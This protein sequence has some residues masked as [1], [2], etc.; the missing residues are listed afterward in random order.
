MGRMVTKLRY[1]EEIII[2]KVVKIY[3]QEGPEKLGIV[4]ECPMH[5]EIEK[6][7]KRNGVQET[8]KRKA[9]D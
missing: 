4:I 5:I 8:E 2:N 6:R 7:V 3:R 9:K 1:G